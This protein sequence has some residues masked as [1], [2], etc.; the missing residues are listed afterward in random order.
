MAKLRA[1][2]EVGTGKWIVKTREEYKGVK[3]TCAGYSRKGSAEAKAAWKANREKKMAEIDGKAA[4]KEGRVKLKQAMTEWYDLY[5]RSKTTHGR[6]RSQRTIQTDE[7]TMAQIFEDLGDILVCDLDSDMLQT[8]F[9]G[10]VKKG[11]GESTIRKRWLLLNQFFAQRNPRDNPMQLCTKPQVQTDKKYMVET[12]DVEEYTTAYTNGEMERLEKVLRH[13]PGSSIQKERALMLCVVMW[14]FLRIGEAIELRV[15]DV[16]LETDTLYIRRQYDERHKQVVIPKDNSKRNLPIS[17]HCRDIL[18]EACGRKNED[19]LVFEGEENQHG[20]RMLRNAALDTLTEACR[21]ANLERH[22]VH[23]L[24]HDGISYMVREGAKPTSIKRWA[25]H[26][27]LSV[28]LDIYYRDT[29]ED[30]EED[31]EL[32]TGKKREGVLNDERERTDY[33]G[34]AERKYKIE[35]G[36]E[37]CRSEVSRLVS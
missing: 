17:K 32:M 27:S 7:S 9:Q 26:K 34:F 31:R 24:R 18:V 5:M 21:I 2:K 15:R 22:K 16:D 13:F 36:V 12:E 11:L 37:R 20:R 14:Q 3:W 19:D 6:P 10:L 23:D 29:A 4:V 33:C 30:D 28:T 1:F 8:Y 35:T 25:G